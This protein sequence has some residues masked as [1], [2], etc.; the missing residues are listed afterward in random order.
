[1]EGR[2]IVEKWPKIYCSVQSPPK[3]TIQ[4]CRSDAWLNS[5]MWQTYF[6]SN[7]NLFSAG[8]SV[9]TLIQG[10]IICKRGCLRLFVPVS[11]SLGILKWGLV[12]FDQLNSGFGTPP[13]FP[14]VPLAFEYL[15]LTQVSIFFGGDCISR[16]FA[17][18]ESSEKTAHP[19]V[20]H[21]L[22]QFLSGRI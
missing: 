20:Y 6:Q 15:P 7:L 13:T 17:N 18:R 12:Q 2:F 4:F 22:S 10:R 14:L 1:M 19:I 21:H 16:I 8:S 5:I 11:P 9:Q 3:E